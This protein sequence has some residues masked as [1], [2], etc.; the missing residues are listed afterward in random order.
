M[1]FIVRRMGNIKKQKLKSTYPKNTNENIIFFANI[2]ILIKENDLDVI[3]GKFSM[4][5]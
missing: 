1:L 5:S 3:I 4:C 2:K